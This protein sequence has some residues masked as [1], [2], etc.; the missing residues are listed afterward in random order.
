MRRRGQDDERGVGWVGGGGRG[1][2]EGWGLAIE[3][4]KYL[5]IFHMY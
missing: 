2:K 1:V 5:E 3:A 4:R